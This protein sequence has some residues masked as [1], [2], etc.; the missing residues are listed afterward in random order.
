MTD[1][2]RKEARG[3]DNMTRHGVSPAT[4][5]PTSPQIL[6]WDRPEPREPKGLREKT[7]CD[8]LQPEGGGGFQD[9]AMVDGAAPS[10]P[11]WVQDGIGRA[12]NNT[13]RVDREG[14]RT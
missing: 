7:A 2:V 11:P 1:L 3:E 4:A 8:T 9:A 6:S 5:V 12:Q 10:P 13:Y 14:V